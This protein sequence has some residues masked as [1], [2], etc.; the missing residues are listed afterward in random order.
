MQGRQHDFVTPSCSPRVDIV[1]GQHYTQRQHEHM[2]CSSAGLPEVTWSYELL[3]YLLINCFPDFSFILINNYR[4]SLKHQTTKHTQLQLHWRSNSNCSLKKC[5]EIMVADL[6]LWGLV[7]GGPVLLFAILSICL[8]IMYM[9]PK[10][11]RGRG[12]RTP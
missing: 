2:N 8:F 1:C 11:S 5:G 7:G 4:L 6:N 12:K 10:G 3:P 9:P